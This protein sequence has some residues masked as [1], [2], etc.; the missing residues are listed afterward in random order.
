MFPHRSCA[1][2]GSEK[3]ESDESLA[4]NWDQATEK[5][6]ERL[7]V[8]VEAP[9]FFRLISP[10]AGPANQSSNKKAHC[11]IYQ[12]RVSAHEGN[13]MPRAHLLREQGVG[14]SNLPAPTN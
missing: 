12:Q 8:G 11:L 14:S 10:G 7:N 1:Q 5:S 9:F 4:R 6:K 13:L 3:L 2:P